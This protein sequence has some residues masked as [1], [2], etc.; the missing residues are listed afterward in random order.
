MRIV[1][2][3]SPQFAVPSLD[4][5]F[6][7]THEVVA[8]VTQPD[9]PKGRNL[10]PQPPPVKIAA[11]RLGIPVLQPVTTKSDVFLQEIKSF[12]PD[13]LVVVAY[14]EILRRALLNLPPY[15]VVNLHASLLPKYRGAAPIP[16]AILRGESHTG[17]TTM[18][19]NEV[20]DGGPIVLQEECP[21]LPA[22]TSD[23]LAKKIAN[24]GAPLLKRTVDLLQ[25]KEI[26]PEPQD[27]TQVTYAPKLR[28]EDGLI[29]WNNPAPWISRQI[30]AFDPW[31]G[32]FSNFRGMRVKFW[33]AHPNEGKS[34]GSPGTVI[35]VMKHSF[36]IAC[37]EGTILEVLEIQPENKPRYPA[38]DFIHGYSIH[39][40]DH[41]VSRL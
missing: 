31:P 38:A 37:G 32:S 18:M 30:R 15:G 29:D 2:M 36:Q 17:A 27:L 22:D 26:T 16:W 12:R 9:R 33:L 1:F 24:L 10:L 8:V 5:I 34:T 4:A 23:T 25:R 7:S 39:V 13:L 35:A 20:M 11:H 19:I 28:K 21:I 41:F 14:G 6:S 3:G 40:E